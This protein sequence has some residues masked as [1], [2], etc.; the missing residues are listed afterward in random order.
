[1]FDKNNSIKEILKN[2]KNSL[3]KDKELSKEK[4]ILTLRFLRL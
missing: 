2:T 1:M 4:E 3:I